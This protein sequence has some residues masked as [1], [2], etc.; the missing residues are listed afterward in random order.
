MRSNLHW[1]VI[2][3][4]LHLK[5]LSDMHS[6]ILVNRKMASN[7]WTEIPFPSQDVTGVCLDGDFRTICIM[8]VYNDCEHNGSLEVVKEYMR[9]AVR[10]HVAGESVQYIWLGDFNQH[11]PL[12][13]KEQNTHLFMKA[14]LEAIR[15]LLNMVAKYD[16]KMAL[17]KDIPTPEASSTKSYT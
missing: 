12:W 2:Y 13:D 4:R 14:A 9:G 1:T 7:N 10:R 16:M 8:N 3:P 5:T 17:P 6:V 15:P 11:H